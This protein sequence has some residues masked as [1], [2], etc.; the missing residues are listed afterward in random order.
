MCIWIDT[1]AYEDSCDEVLLYEYL[2]H[3][4]N[5]LAH[6]YKYFTKVDYYDEFSLFCASRLCLRLKNP[7]QF[8]FTEAGTPRLTRIKSILNYIK[9]VIYPYKVDFEQEYYS[10]DIDDL[11]T[12]GDNNFD[13]GEY[14]GEECKIFSNLDFS[15]SLGDL[16][17]VIRSFLRKIP[18]K[19]N[20]PEWHN[21]Y[22]SC[23][24]TILNSITASK[25]Q[26]SEVVEKDTLTR[27]NRLY[28]LLRTKEPILYH[29]DVSYTNYIKTLVAEIRQ[30][31]TRELTIELHTYI[32]TEVS[33]KNLII[34]ALKDDD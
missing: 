26:L 29:L 25:E 22:L 17:T 9:T 2:Y 33:L 18:R 1:N 15:L 23:L 24:L 28:A 10:H 11:V 8:E 7:K 31:L 27:L 30:L 14:F 32:P 4:V 3:L 21:I 13:F 19:R 12:L 5:M 16:T 34:T 20:D 6:E